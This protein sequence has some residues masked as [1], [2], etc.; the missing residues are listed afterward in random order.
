MTITLN[1]GSLT[2]FDTREGYSFAK[3]IPLEGGINTVC[4]LLVTWVNTQLIEG[5]IL[6]TVILEEYSGINA[7]VSVTS[8]KGLRTFV[9]TSE[10]LPEDLGLML[11]STWE[12]LKFTNAKVQA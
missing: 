5:E 9:V 11:L 12:S 1:N 10:Q 4:E 7:A 3:D 8:D 6:S 2:L